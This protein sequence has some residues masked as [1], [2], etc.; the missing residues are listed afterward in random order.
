V[1]TVLE[2]ALHAVCCVVSCVRQQHRGINSSEHDMSLSAA[3]SRLAPN[4]RAEALSER[5]H[6]LQQRGPGGAAPS[7]E[8]QRQAVACFAEAVRLT[9]ARD[10]VYCFALGQ[11]ILA[12]RP[13]DLPAAIEAFRLAACAAP[14]WFAPK[15]ALEMLGAS[16]EGLKGKS[17]AARQGGG[18]DGDDDD[19]VDMPPAAS[20]K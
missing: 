5:G 18:G 3:A 9:S 15:Q 12:A 11:A 2:S 20:R 4:P 10:K 16:L 17:I 14:D 19:D 8:A 13:L 1:L 7:A 6:A